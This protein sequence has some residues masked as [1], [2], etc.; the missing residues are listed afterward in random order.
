VFE[1]DRT[2]TALWPPHAGVPTRKPRNAASPLPQHA[3]CNETTTIMNRLDWVQ[4]YCRT[5]NDRK[6]VN[7]LGG[8][9]KLRVLRLDDHEELFTGEPETGRGRAETDCLVTENRATFGH[10]RPVSRRHVTGR[11]CSGFGW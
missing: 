6:P 5:D 9:P 10:G 4:L 8:E 2:I 3:I 11:G 7:E 1:K